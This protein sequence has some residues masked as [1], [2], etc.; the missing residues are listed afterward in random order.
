[1]NNKKWEILD[2]KV[3]TTRLILT[4]IFFKDSKVVF[5]V[6]KNITLMWLLL[7]KK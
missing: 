5:V 4:N 1:M 3:S 7:V 2:S 6:M